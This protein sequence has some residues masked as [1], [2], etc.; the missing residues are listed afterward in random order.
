MY[1][2]RKGLLLRAVDGDTTIPA[3]DITKN[4][5]FRQLLDRVKAE[6]ASTMIFLV[7][8]DGTDTYFSASRHANGLGVR[9]GKLPIAGQGPIDLGRF[10]N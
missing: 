9:N 1:A 2:E 10:N 8:E 7:R 6:A 3:A 4:T 5:A